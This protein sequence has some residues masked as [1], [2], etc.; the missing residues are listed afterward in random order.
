MRP[1]PLLRRR[2]AGRVGAALVLLAVI[3]PADFQHWLGVGWL[4]Q[5]EARRSGQACS[6]AAAPAPAQIAGI[7]PEQ[8]IRG[9]KAEQIL[10]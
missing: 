1:A 4:M 8:V 5:A 10:A 7:E 6:T 2:R 3:E 9:A